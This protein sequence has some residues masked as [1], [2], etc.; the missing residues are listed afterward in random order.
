VEHS[1]DILMVFKDAQRRGAG[2]CE[3]SRCSKCEK[4]CGKAHANELVRDGLVHLLPPFL[5]EIIVAQRPSECLGHA[6]GVDIDPFKS[7]PDVL[8]VTHRL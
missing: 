3:Q 1:S 7:Q 8:E 2:L 6:S 5:G 4:N